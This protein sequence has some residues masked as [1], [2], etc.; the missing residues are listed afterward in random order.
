M[1]SPRTM[2]LILQPS[3]TINPTTPSKKPTTPT[4]SPVCA[5]GSVYTSSG[6]P[7]RF[8]AVLAGE[9]AETG[10]SDVDGARERSNSKGSLLGRG[11]GRGFGDGLLGC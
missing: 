7:V 1:Y 4:G 2:S 3:T 5:S 10:P 11:R 9:T 6:A 8:P